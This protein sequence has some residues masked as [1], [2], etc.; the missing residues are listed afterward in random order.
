ML[1]FNHGVSTGSQNGG[2]IETQAVSPNAWMGV[3]YF[4][5]L[6]FCPKDELHQWFIGLYG[7]HIIRPPLH[8]GFAATD[9][10]SHPLLSNEA[11][12]RVFKRLADRFQG[13]VSDRP[14]NTAVLTDQVWDLA[15]A[16]TFTRS[17]PN[18]RRRRDG[19]PPAS[20][21]RAFGRKNRKDTQTVQVWNVP[22]RCRNQEGQE[23]CRWP[24]MTNICLVFTWHMYQL[25]KS[26][27]SR[28]H[29]VSP[30]L[31]IIRTCWC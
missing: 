4:N 27:F 15:G 6:T 10:N 11:V 28:V 7:E 21:R 14:L 9:G 19:D 3:L 25:N 8:K 13:V 12:N 2:W 16:V 22:A 26:C 20:N 24:D 29:D 1:H 5:I 30:A 23:V 18:S 17:T 31:A